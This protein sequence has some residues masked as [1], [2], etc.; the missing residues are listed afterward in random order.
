MANQRTAQIKE[1]KARFFWNKDNEGFK[2]YPCTNYSIENST[3]SILTASLT[4]HDIQLD[5]KK[6]YIDITDKDITI[7]KT[8]NDSMMPL[9]DLKINYSKPNAVLIL[10]TV[11][12]TF[13]DTK[14]EISAVSGFVIK[15][16][17][18]IAGVRGMNI[19]F[20]HAAYC[21]TKFYLSNYLSPASF[22]T[23]AFNPSGDDYT[24]FKEVDKLSEK[25]LAII[26]NE[27][28]R[29]EIAITDSNDID[30]LLY[31]EIKTRNLEIEDKIKK[32]LENIEDETNLPIMEYNSEDKL[33]DEYNKFLFTSFFSANDDL[34]SMLLRNTTDN[35]Y[36]IL[37]TFYH[38]EDVEID[39]S[40]LNTVIEETYKTLKIEKAQ[41][42]LF[43]E[44]KNYKEF[45]CNL[46]N[47]SAN[48]KEGENR[49]AKAVLYI[50]SNNFGAQLVQ[51][52]DNVMS[53][54][55]MFPDKDLPGDIVLI[56][57][58]QYLT[59]FSLKHTIDTN[60][61][62]GQI[63]TLELNLGDVEKEINELR[64]QIEEHSKYT[65]ANLGEFIV[66]T[67]FIFTRY[68]GSVCNLTC[69]YDPT[70]EIGKYYKVFGDK[71]EEGEAPTLFYGFLSTV[72]HQRQSDFCVTRLFFTHV[73]NDQK[74]AEI[75]RFK[76]KE[77]ND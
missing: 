13:S 64:E 60:R 25:L 40:F 41:N 33:R 24:K 38:T 26:E 2:E 29:A 75:K 4:I 52:S 39:N 45:K 6:V 57:S 1:V 15:A 20:V 27:Q 34:W 66:R 32:F 22:T 10:E 8:I 65:T 42:S 49:I 72:M 53:N 51:N 12:Y 50:K 69:A 43:V 44:F 55:I 36:Q 35:Y 14:T 58:P 48:L 16:D 70:I 11:D 56:E 54:Y 17:E 19:T 30:N 46:I 3:N 18:S 31:T 74:L 61:I 47:F 76:K 71:P 67:G 59:D 73:L 62:V 23:E 68:R 37:T 77:Q 28:N 63:Q 21:F 9:L 7:Q 5:A